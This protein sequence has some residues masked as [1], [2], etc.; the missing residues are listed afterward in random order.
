VILF[1]AN[2]TMVAVPPGPDPMW[3]YRRG[4]I[5]DAIQ[6]AQRMLLSRAGGAESG[7]HVK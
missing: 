5:A 3:D 1:E 6:A 4:S 7:A 2:A